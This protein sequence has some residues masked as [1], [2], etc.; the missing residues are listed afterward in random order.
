M[1][2][3][4]ERKLQAVVSAIESGVDLDL[5]INRAKELQEMREKQKKKIAERMTYTEDDLEK[6]LRECLEYAFDIESH[7]NTMRMW[8]V[9]TFINKI[10]LSDQEVVIL[11]RY[12]NNFGDEGSR[13]NF[14]QN[15]SQPVYQFINYSY[16]K[17][18]FLLF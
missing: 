2:A 3:E 1:L 16:L 18:V 14:V 10:L 17:A 9:S 13:F 12:N 8:F 6:S 4:T 5:L 15:Y 7:D 11:F